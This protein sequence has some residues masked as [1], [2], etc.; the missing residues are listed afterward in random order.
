MFFPKHRKIWVLA[1]EASGD[2]LGASLIKTLRYYDPSLRLRGVGGQEMEKCGFQSLFPMEYLSVMGLTEILPRLPRLFWCMSQAIKDITKFK[3]DI[4]LTID[5]PGF[6]FRLLRKIAHIPTIRIHYVA[7]QIWAW[8][9]DKFSNYQGVWDKLL[10]L[11]PFEAKL[12]NQHHL[13]ASF[14]GHPILQQ[15]GEKGDGQRFC[16]KYHIGEDKKLLLLLPG[17]RQ[18]ELKRLLPIFK[19]VVSQLHR[20]R[21]DVVCVFIL[22]ASSCSYVQKMIRTWSVKPFLISERQDKLDAYRRADL[23]LSKS[24]TSTTE[25]ALHSIAFMTVYKVNPVTAYLVRRL[26]HLPYVTMMNILARQAIVPEFLQADCTAPRLTRAVINMLDNPVMRE[27][28][29]E[30]LRMV[31]GQLKSPTGRSP[32]QQAAYEIFNMLKS[33]SSSVEKRY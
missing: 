18:G 10:C 23:A 9:S 32:S 5:S 4:V 29:I 15:L 3:P 12:F 30:K 6:S 24:G 22:T 21:R 31:F 14:V 25:L 20:Q 19:D 33:S 13:N 26:I 8:K 27:E 1:G 7:P 16:L 17:S 11:F 2:I 28:Q